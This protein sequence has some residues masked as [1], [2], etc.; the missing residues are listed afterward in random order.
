MEEN[1]ENK[2]SYYAVIPA[3]VRYDNKLSANA[4][5]LYG[6]I[7]A[8]CN[9]KGFCWASNK[10][11]AELYGV[12]DRSIKTWINQLVSNDYIKVNRCSEIIK[13]LEKKGLV[14]ISYKY[15]P[16][17]KLIEKRIIKV[18]EISNIG[19]RDSEEGIRNLDRGYSENCEDNNTIFNNTFN[20]RDDENKSTK[21]FI[22]PSIEE[23]KKYCI[24]RNNNIDAEHFVN[25]YDSIGWMVGK[26]KMKDWKAAVRTWERNDKSKKSKVD[27]LPY[28]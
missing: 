7:T 28:L 10:Y 5:L 1:L 6:E 17:T 13:S 19:I 2:P 18:F 11:F 25:Y 21:K 20:N 16:N 4:K 24:E 15:K 9:K 23:V 14:K 22:S 26:N 27:E 3:E 12:T 8:L